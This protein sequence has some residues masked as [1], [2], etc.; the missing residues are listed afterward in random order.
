LNFFLKKF[1]SVKANSV[2]IL[3]IPPCF[4]TEVLSSSGKR[5]LLSLP[6][7]SFSTE[8]PSFLAE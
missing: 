4:I 1:S 7:S 5:T 2:F 6:F 8:L 3:L